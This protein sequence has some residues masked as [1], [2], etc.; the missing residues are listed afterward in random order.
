MWSGLWFLT[1]SLTLAPLLFSHTHLLLHRTYSTLGSLHL[2]LPLLESPHSV[3][4]FLCRSPHFIQFSA[5]LNLSFDMFSSV[6]SL[7]RVRLCD[8]MNRSTPGLPVH[9]QLPEFTQTHV[10]WVSDAIQPSHPLSSPSPPAPN[11]SQH[12]SL[13]QWVNSLHEVAKVGV[14]ASAS[15]PPKKSQGWSPSEWTGWISLQSL[16]SSHAKHHLFGFHD[17]QWADDLQTYILS[18]ILNFRSKHPKAS[19]LTKSSRSTHSRQDLASPQAPLLLSSLSGA[20]T[21][22][23]AKA[24]GITLDFSFPLFSTSHWLFYSLKY[25][26]RTFFVSEDSDLLLDLVDLPVYQR[27]QMLKNTDLLIT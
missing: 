3:S 9:H 26:L 13:F 19:C 4:C 24:L 5:L 25:F 16:W 18:S 8:P 15:F 6:R 11:P 1:S 10:H 2:L 12:Q 14:S 27:I 17:H 23:Q 7:S 22:V 20:P 21:A